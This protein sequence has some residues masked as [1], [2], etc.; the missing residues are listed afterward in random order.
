MTD[1]SSSSRQIN[2]GPHTTEVVKVLAKEIPS[3]AALDSIRAKA[4]SIIEQCIDPNADAPANPNDGLLYGLIQSGKTSILT[5]AAA[6]AADNGFDII[7]ILTSDIDLLYDQTLERIRKALR[8]LR[9]LGKDDWKDA[10]RFNRQLR[11]VPFVIV[12]SKNG[13]KLHS[14]LNAFKTAKPN[15]FA[16]FIIDD[17]ADQA[18]LN[19]LESKGGDQ[20]SKINEAISDFRAYFTVN[21]YLQVTA[22]PQALF[23]Q[24]PDH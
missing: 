7:L 24:R 4:K 14:L 22:T 11:S 10:T 12:C 13:N 1:Q 9:V 15:D 16:L 19:T 2:E 5:V 23:L 20:K 8:G 21:S 3:Q 18:S 17:E 6:M